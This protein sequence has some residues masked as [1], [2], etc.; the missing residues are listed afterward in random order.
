MWG[1]E[2][3]KNQDV[4]YDSQDK[5]SM[6]IGGG[7]DSRLNWI[8]FVDYETNKEIQVWSKE[9]YDYFKREQ[10]VENADMM[11]RMDIEQL[12]KDLN[13]SN[14]VQSYQNLPVNQ[15]INII[16]Q[17]QPIFVEEEVIEPVIVEQLEPVVVKQSTKTD[18]SNYT[19]ETPY[20]PANE[21]IVKNKELLNPT[22][23]TSAISFYNNKKQNNT[24]REILWSAIQKE[25]ISL[26][27][28]SN[29]SLAKWFA[30]VQKQNWKSKDKIDWKAWT[31]D[32]SLLW[33]DLS[34]YTEKKEAVSNL[35]SN[36]WGFTNVYERDKVYPNEA[37]I[38]IQDWTELINPNEAKISQLESERADLKNQMDSIQRQIDSQT[39][40]WSNTWV[41]INGQHYWNSYSGWPSLEYKINTLVRQ[42]NSKW[43][44]I[45][46][47]NWL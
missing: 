1:W 7:I 28:F 36:N 9:H 12:L 31:N 2:K 34:I 20:T 13:S 45:D 26:S 43:D 41:T 46:S 38:D 37:V 5:Q 39:R 22:Q 33:L 11:V 25:W 35:P 17:P 4:V 10:W 15:K 21:K 24:W 40:N 42:Y 27:D 18:T 23:L 19:T 30:E 44:E 8:T 32:I 6:S 14:V 47:L 3:M 16:Q 29:E